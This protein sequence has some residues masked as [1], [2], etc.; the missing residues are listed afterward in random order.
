[1]GVEERRKGSRWMGVEGRRKGRRGG[2]EG[3]GGEARSDLREG[4]GEERYEVMIGLGR[5]AGESPGPTI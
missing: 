4:V 3:R 1:M 2:G 5:P